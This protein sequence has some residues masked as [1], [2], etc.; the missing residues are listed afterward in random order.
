MKKLL[1]MAVAACCH[2]GLQQGTRPQ[3]IRLRRD[4][5]SHF[6][7][8]EVHAGENAPCFG[9]GYERIRVYRHQYSIQPQRGSGND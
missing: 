9:N 1:I 7:S 2:G 4:F 8:Q 6:Q 5:G 3:S